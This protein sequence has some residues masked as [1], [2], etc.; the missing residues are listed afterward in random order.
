MGFGRLSRP[1]L[2]NFWRAGRA[3]PSNPAW[4][5]VARQMLGTCHAIPHLVKKDITVKNDILA[6]LEINQG[7]QDT[8]EGI[9]EWWLLKQRIQNATEVVRTALDQLVVEHKVSVKRGADGRVHYRLDQLLAKRADGP[10]AR[11][12]RNQTS[13]LGHRNSTT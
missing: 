9:V 3:F 13:A 11:A 5:I 10:G 2:D 4:I 7:A 12:G 8:L 6:Y 1:R